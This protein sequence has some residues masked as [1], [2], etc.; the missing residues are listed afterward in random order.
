MTFSQRRGLLEIPQRLRPAQMT[1]ELRASLWN[2]LHLTLWDR[3]FFLYNG[4]SHGHIMDF[5]KQL[6]FEHFKRPF[7][8]IPRTPPSVLKTLEEYFFSCEWNEVYDFLEAVLMLRKSEQI[9]QAL[10]N[11]LSRELAAYSIVE[12]RFVEITDAGELAALDEALQMEDKFAVVSAHLKR[13][14]ELLSDRQSPD[15]RNSVKESISAVEAI[16]RIITE[17]KGATLGDALKVLEER[18]DLHKALKDGFSKLYG[19]TSDANGVR[20]AMQ[21]EPNL[22]MP[23]AK[24]FLLSCASF[25]NYLKARVGSSAG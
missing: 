6:W 14:L 7:S 13:A 24:Y 25:V 5:A 8:D 12:S 4:N 19:Y 20:H 17:K 15:F 16:A 3:P 21:D 23:E 10:N 18:H 22:D 2:A 9:A 11:V 1:A